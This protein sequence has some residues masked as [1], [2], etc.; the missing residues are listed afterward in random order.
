M[1][2]ILVLTLVLMTTMT[3]LALA[4]TDAG[5]KE[6]G[7]NVTYSNTSYSN[8]STKNNFTSFGFVF[9]YF[10][11]AYWSVGADYR[12]SGTSTEP[13]N[14]DSSI[15]TYQ[16]ISL[17][18]DLLAGGPTKTAIPYIGAHIGNTSTYFESGGS[19]DDSSTTSYG[20][21][22]GLKIFP[23]ERVSVNLELDYTTTTQEDY[24]G[25]DYDVDTVSLFVGASFYF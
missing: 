4:G 25:E 15:S 14:G 19:S 20:L 17:R 23:S 16:T 21:Q 22:G 9:N 11:N 13:E 18:T 1:K 8:S 5:Y 12:L 10:F 7:V 2:K 24:Y 6:L 3:G